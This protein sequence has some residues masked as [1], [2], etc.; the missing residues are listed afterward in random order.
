MCIRDSN[1]PGLGIDLSGGTILVYEVD[2]E[3]TAANTAEQEGDG[4]F[5]PALI[6]ALKNRIDP[7]GTKEIVIRP[8]G[9]TQIEIII[10][11][12]PPAEIEQIKRSIS[13]AGYLKFRILA[14]RT[15]HKNIW[16]LG[17]QAL[18]DPQLQTQSFI[19]RDGMRVAEWVEIGR[20]KAPEGELGALRISRNAALTRELEPGTVEALMVVDPDERFRVDGQHLSGVAESFDPQN[21]APCVS[22][23][24]NPI[25]SKLF[26]TLTSNN[27]PDKQSGV[28]S[29]LGIVMDDVLLSAPTIQSTISTN[30]QITGNFTSEEVQFLVNVLKGG[31][32]PAVLRPEPNS[33]NNISST[34]GLSLIHI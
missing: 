8:Y 12:T 27:L 18:A 21:G 30:G 19:E 29:Q 16:Q 1:K 33:Q 31:R 11:K 3:K 22:F 4:N 14:D 17:E 2:E 10:P 34:L 28:S 13:Q 23:R 25:G 7:S 6:Q 26:L 5:M 24:M 15:R 20:D 9:P 32:L